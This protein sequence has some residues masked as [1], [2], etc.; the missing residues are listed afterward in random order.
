L[1]V[2]KAPGQ[3]PLS[4]ATI[5]AT[6]TNLSNGYFAKALST[7]SRYSVPCVYDI[8]LADCPF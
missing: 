7:F 5:T 2:G 3:P 8:M 6:I 4:L 1:A